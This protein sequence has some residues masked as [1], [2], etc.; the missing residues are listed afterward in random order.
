MKKDDLIFIFDEYK[1]ISEVYVVKEVRADGRILNVGVLE[2]FGNSFE[3]ATKVDDNNIFVAW[4]KNDKEYKPSSKLIKTPDS[5]CSYVVEMSQLRNSEHHWLFTE[6]EWG[7]IKEY[8]HFPTES[9]DAKVFANR[10][11]TVEEF[12]SMIYGNCGQVCIWS[13]ITRDQLDGEPIADDVK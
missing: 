1:W 2:E 11:N 10:E 13:F 9:G 4:M 12:Y 7:E 6:S 5:E 8:M 3:F